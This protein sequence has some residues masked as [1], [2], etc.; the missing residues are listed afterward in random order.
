MNTT[1]LSSTA[2]P[3]LCFDQGLENGQE[4]RL[5]LTSG[6]NRVKRNFRHSSLLTNLLSVPDGKISSPMLPILAQT[7]RQVNARLITSTPG[8]G[9]HRSGPSATGALVVLQPVLVHA[10]PPPLDQ[11]LP[12][13][14]TIGVLV[15]MPQHV[16]Q[17]DEVQPFLPADVVGPL[18][19]LQ[20]RGRGGEL[21]GGIVAAAMPGGVGAQ[22]LTDAPGDAPQDFL[23]V[24]DG[25]Y[26][27]GGDLDVH[28]RLPGLAAV[29]PDPLHVGSAVLFDRRRV[30]FDVHVHGIQTRFDQQL[31][32]LRGHVAVG[33]A[34]VVEATLAGE[35]E[36]VEGPFQREGGFVEADGSALAAPAHCLSDEILWGHVASRARRRFGDVPVLAPGTV[37]VAAPTAGRQGHAAGVEMI[38]G[39]LLDGVG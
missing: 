20:W 25:R 31:Q 11:Q 36:H 2:F 28:P 5:P 16:A 34:G 38:E 24:V 35:P 3:L 7:S 17:V 30:P 22:L 4:Q 29:P 15:P 37:E 18:Q 19:G 32:R 6:G 12:T 33:H 9:Y 8:T 1:S 23:I 39:L 10:Q 14:R 27:Q 21:V 26:H 13:P